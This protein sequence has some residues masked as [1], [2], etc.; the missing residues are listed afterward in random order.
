MKLVKL[1]NVRPQALL[2]LLVG[3]LLS[4][5]HAH[6]QTP[7]PTPQPSSSVAAKPMAI[8]AYAANMTFNAGVSNSIKLLLKG[9]V[10]YSVI[11]S[12]SNGQSLTLLLCQDAT[13]SRTIAWP[14]NVRLAGGGLML[15]KTP[16]K[17][18]TVTMLFDGF[19][20]Y[21][22]ARSMNLNQ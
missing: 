11:G 4:I 1:T 18:D 8:A 20:W 2:P 19:N 7:R 17:C 16:N 10:G 3:C 21:E 22:T 15:T 6:S 14:A 5:S 12:G 9:N 13:G